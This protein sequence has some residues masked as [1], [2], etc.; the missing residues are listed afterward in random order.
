MR[1][2][3]GRLIAT[4]A[5][6]VL[7]M[8]AS[9]VVAL[10]AGTTELAAETLADRVVNGLAERLGELV[11]AAIAVGF[12]VL[13]LREIRDSMRLRSQAEREAA[14]L[15]KKRFEADREERVSIKAFMDSEA[16][17]FEPR[18]KQMAEEIANVLRRD[19]DWARRALEAAK[20]GPYS[21]GAFGE[22]SAHFEAEKSDLAHQFVQY[23]F[24]RCGRLAQSSHV[25][26]MV[27]AGTT[28][29]PLFGEIGE[30]SISQWELERFHDAPKW[31]DRLHLVTNNLP[32]LEKL[33]QTGRP[34]TGRHSPLAI[35]NAYLLPGNPM[36]VFAAV[37]GPQTVAAIGEL[38]KAAVREAEKKAMP[39]PVFIA[40]VVGNWVRIRSS[41]PRCPI[42]MARG[43]QGRHLEAKNAFIH[44]ADEVYVVSPLGKI[45]NIPGLTGPVSVKRI[46]E[47]MGLVNG[48]PNPDEEPY[49]DVTLNDE[50]AKVTKLIT[51]DRSP[52]SLLHDHSVSIR[53]A[54][55]VPQGT[56]TVEE[57]AAAAPEAVPHI[58]FPLTR[59]RSGRLP[60]EE[61][62][63]DFPHV[64]T[65]TTEVLKLFKASLRQ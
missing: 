26:L 59:T 62:E 15:E 49:Q 51:T 8:A 10:A 21:G 19:P 13:H 54:L 50:K 35:A 64:R 63:L 24:K 20:L 39:P 2:S 14:E 55:G 53:G 9:R 61:L 7:L 56:A 25:Y 17:R 38:K 32:G 6:V 5:M 36:P 31:I 45:F 18:A 44:E 52:G 41:D 40:L 34:G 27:D 12:G 57:F 60:E 16:R 47:A 23:L 58:F 28:L 48:S 37:G 33:I 22:R 1:S 4:A 46:N 3:R 11:L 42:P 30:W 29:F 43:E 65:R